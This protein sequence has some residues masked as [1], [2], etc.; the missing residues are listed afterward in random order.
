MIIFLKN[1]L[2]FTDALVQLRPIFFSYEREIRTFAP[3]T[4]HDSSFYSR[5]MMLVLKY[6]V[7]IPRHRL[8]PGFFRHGISR[9]RIPA[10]LPERF[11]CSSNALVRLLR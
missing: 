6:V 5:K 3:A 8:D 11:S 4:N 1:I 10:R 9:L 7:S 2:F